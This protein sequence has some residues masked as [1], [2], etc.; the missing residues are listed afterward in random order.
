M[1]KLA[2]LV[3][4]ILFILTSIA[5][6]R[7]AEY[8]LKF[9]ISDK[10]ELSTIT[11]YISIDNVKDRTVFAYA[12]DKQLEKFGHLGYVYEILPHPGT[13][14]N[15]KMSTDKADIMEW[16]SY[17]TYTAY[18]D[19]MYQFE[20]DYPGLCEIVDIGGTV[21][22]RRLLYAKISSNVS[23]EE[24]EPEVMYSSSIH[25]DETTGYVLMLRLI[26]YFL[27]NYG[28]DPFVT[29]MVDSC[30]IWINPLANPDGTYAGGNNSVYSATRYNANGVDMN[31]N[32]I[33]PDDGLHPDGNAW[34][35]ETIAQM[36]FSAEHSFVISANFHGG[37]EVVNY[38]WDTWSRLCADNDWWVM[39][40]RDFADSAQYYSPSGFLTDLNNGITNGYAWYTITGGRQDFMNYFRHCREVTLEISDTKL[41]SASSLPAWWN[42]LKSSMLHYLEQGLYGFRGIVTDATTGDPLK[43]MIEI[44]GHDLAIDSSYVFTDPDVGD[45]HRMVEAGTYDIKFSAPGY[46]PKTLK[47]K[48]VFDYSGTRV[49]A[50]LVERTD[51]PELIVAS[52]SAGAIDPGD[53]IAFTITL[54]NDGIGNGNNVSAE[55][56]SDDAYVTITQSS[57]TFPKI[58][59]EGGTAESNSEFMVSVSSSC[60]LNYLV[61]FDLE[62]IGDNGYTDTLTFS[63]LVGQIIEDFETGNLTKFDWVTTGDANWYVTSSGPYEGSYTARSGSITHNDST[64]LYLNIDILSAGT[65][66]FMYKVSSES[67][68]DY[69]RFSIDGSVKGSW[70]GEVGWTQASYAVTA[71]NHTFTWTYDKDGSESDGSDCGWVDYIILP[72]VDFSVPLEILTTSVPDWTADFPYS[73][74]LSASGGSEPYTWIDESSDLVGTGLTLSTTGLLSGTPTSA[75]TISFT[76]QVLDSESNSDTQP[77]SFTI[78]PPIT[79]S[80]DSLP[81]GYTDE[82]YSMQLTSTGGTGSKTWTDKNHEL[83]GTGLTLSS[84]GLLS[85][86]VGAVGQITFTSVVEDNIS[87]QDEKIFTVAFS[88]AFV[89]GDANGDEAVNIADAVFLVN[90][91]FKGGTAPDPVEAGDVNNDASSNIGDAVYLI[92]YV[93]NGGPAPVC[94]D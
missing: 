56:M 27:S 80:T 37:A 49:D 82:P 64:T 41:L 16:D 77:L 26:D 22:G 33:D 44:V 66:S 14:I 85:G 7:P 11:K 54:Q 69:L 48:T 29:R 28:T 52:H 2:C 70:S 34:Q 72:P 38:P 55:L 36:D 10:Q 79:V 63:L 65:I 89:C 47:T 13:L 81:S 71:G 35:P 32:F 6:A 4:F 12:N 23:I 18:V 61:D 5:S 84:T 42:Y 67:G 53:N 46:T 93:F 50:T 68:Y 86:T 39:V 20:T 75:G 19:M 58:W 60:P 30:E 31:R 1:K 25:G 59:A 94:T 92:Q 17:P 51:P 3:L 21:E 24:D 8:Y 43:A 78:N 83:D 45:Y 76:A 73:Q 88:Q 9:E 40:S 62:V 91:I 90:Y 57:S 15:P 87:A 74:Q